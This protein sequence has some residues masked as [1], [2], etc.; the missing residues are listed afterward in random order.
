MRTPQRRSDT[1]NVRLFLIALALH[2]LSSAIYGL[3]FNLHLLELGYP[4]ELLGLLNALPSAMALGIGLPAGWWAHRIGHRMGMILGGLMMAIGTVGVGL[5]ISPL[6]VGLG[7]GLIGAGYNLFFIA[8]APFLM[9]S[10]PKAERTRLFALSSAILF[11]AG[12]VGELIGGALPDLFRRLLPV[13]PTAY[14]GPILL[15]AGLDALSVLP[16]L[17]IRE[18]ASPPRAEAPEA[19]LGK[20]VFQ[21]QIVSMA[22]PPFLIGMGAAMSVPFFN[23]YFHERYGLPDEILGVLFALTSVCTGL[24]TL[25]APAL[26][27]WIGRIP[28]VVLTQGLSVG[29]LVGMALTDH[30]LWAA[31]AMVAR[32]ALMNMASPLYLEFCMEQVPAAARAAV[33]GVLNV[34]WEVGWMIGAA[35][36]GG[37]QPRYGLA[38]MFL[39]T[40][41]LYG[42]GTIYQY[43]AFAARDR[44]PAAPPARLLQ[45]PASSEGMA[46]GA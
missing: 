35:L 10:A 12:F 41:V 4:W 31:L 45:R 11:W 9:E 5:G 29:F 46:S 18:P 3:W 44:A 17:G 33:N 30:A 42:I 7:V 28:A 6:G 25:W 20:E 22:V 27:R 38:S 21:G 14:A 26:A 37:L 16:L 19:R 43:V 1:R 8:Y 13:G 39:T 36:S 34:A 32:G 40:A 15:T 24:A 23:V 2:G